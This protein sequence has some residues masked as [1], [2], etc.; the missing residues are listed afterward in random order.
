MVTMKRVEA[1]QIRVLIVDDDKDETS[2]LA[3]FLRHDQTVGALSIDSVHSIESAQRWLRANP[4][5]LLILIV[6][7]VLPALDADGEGMKKLDQ[8]KSRLIDRYMAMSKEKIAGKSNAAR[9]RLW[10]EIAMI[11]KKIDMHFDLEGGLKVVEFARD[12]QRSQA[13]DLEGGLR[14]VVSSARSKGTIRAD[15]YEL[16]PESHIRFADKPVSLGEIV[17]SVCGLL[18][19][20]SVSLDDPLS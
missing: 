18:R 10:L 4:T 15:F 7:M 13:S 6:D 8:R 16:I 11:E 20:C 9:H 19:T 17:S 1:R 12:W 14:V 5:S 2:V 3:E